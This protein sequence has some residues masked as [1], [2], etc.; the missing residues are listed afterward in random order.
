VLEVFDDKT[1]GNFYKRGRWFD[2]SA[3]SGIAIDYTPNHTFSVIFWAR[4]ES[5]GILYN[6]TF[7]VRVRD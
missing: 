1:G 4:V 3:A 2:G 7:K 6:G 5:D